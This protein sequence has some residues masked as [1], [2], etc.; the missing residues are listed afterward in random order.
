MDA[1]LASVAKE[2]SLAVIILMIGV[3]GLS[4]AVGVLFAAWRQDVRDRRDNM[5]VGLEKLTEAVNALRLE[6]AKGLQ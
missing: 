5:A 2:G 3:L 4:T 6:F 1:L